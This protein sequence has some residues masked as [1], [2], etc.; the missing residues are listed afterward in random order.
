[1]RIR[2]MGTGAATAAPL[3]FCR[4]DHCRELREKG[5]F[6][7]RAALLINDDLIIDFGPDVPQ[8]AAELNIDLTKVTTILQTHSH[9]DHFD[10]GHIV[11]RI[12]GYA[13]E[14]LPPLTMI[15]S[16]LTMEHIR[17]K[18]MREEGD[19]ADIFSESAC[20]AMNLFAHSAT[21]DEMLHT[22]RYDILPIP[23]PHDVR[24][25]SVIYLVHD[26]ADEKT[27]LYATDCPPFTDEVWQTLSHFKLDCAIMDHTYGTLPRTAPCTSHMDAHQFASALCRL[28]KEGILKPGAPAYAT[29]ISHEAHGTVALME[30]FAADNHYLL[31][32][33]GQNIFL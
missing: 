31:P 21:P 18:L 2:F 25:G 10:A 6:R 3:P 17:E 9:A 30:A 5:L 14:N 15:G 29:H 33:D 13:P 16:P 28:R 12:P 26:T 23:V 24:D 22:C 32:V 4:C 20:R 11:T 7:R 1:M 8:M 19:D 27:I